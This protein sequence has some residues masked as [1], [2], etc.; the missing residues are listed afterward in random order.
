MSVEVCEIPQFSYTTSEQ[1]GMGQKSNLSFEFSVW[2][3]W[4]VSEQE[5]TSGTEAV[6]GRV[7]HW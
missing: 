4:S 2:A 6:A 1:K 3:N 5:E 7:S